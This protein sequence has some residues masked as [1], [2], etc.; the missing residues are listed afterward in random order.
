MKK[1]GLLCFPHLKLYCF[2]SDEYSKKILKDRGYTNYENLDYIDKKFDLI[3]SLH[4]LEHL[5]NIETIF[6]LPKLL[7]NSGLLFFE[8]P[9][10]PTKTYY[11]NRPYDCPHLLFFTEKSIEIISKK[12]SLR[13]INFSSSSYSYEDDIHVNTTGSQ[14][15]LACLNN[16]NIFILYVERIELI[17]VVLFFIAY[18]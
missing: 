13:F 5:T 3:I 4:S 12:M 16:L 14:P 7:N 15:D 6:K 18:L 17:N 11:I 1:N 10:C 8:V 2:E 9:N